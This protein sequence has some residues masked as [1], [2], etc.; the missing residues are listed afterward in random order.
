[1]I[2]WIFA[3]SS[4]ECCFIFT[5]FVKVSLRYFIFVLTEYAL[6]P[7]IIFELSVLL[8]KYN[9][10]KSTPLIFQLVYIQTCYG[11]FIDE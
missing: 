4:F 6:L 10:L 5:S 11:Y 8:A 3:F 2:V 7:T 1:M 9:L